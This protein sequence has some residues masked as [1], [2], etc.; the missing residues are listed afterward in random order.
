VCFYG[1]NGQS[2]FVVYTQHTK[3]AAIGQK[4]DTLGIPNQTDGTVTVTDAW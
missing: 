1:L 3:P 4:E 2:V